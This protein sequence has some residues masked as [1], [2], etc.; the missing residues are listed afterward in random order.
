MLSETFYPVGVLELLLDVDV[1]AELKT[2]MQGI[3]GAIVNDYWYEM[4]YVDEFM[5]ARDE[6]K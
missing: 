2:H 3:K 1:F 6:A 5:T 4:K